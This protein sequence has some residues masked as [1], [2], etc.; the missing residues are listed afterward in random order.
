[1]PHTNNDLQAAQQAMQIAY[2]ADSRYNSVVSLGYR[3]RGT[4][5]IMPLG[6]IP[7]G[8][9]NL[10]K[11]DICPSKDYYITGNTLARCYRC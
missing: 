5:C 3:D 9:V 2:G 10:N 11:L 7:T 4:E 1:M 8:K 6:Y